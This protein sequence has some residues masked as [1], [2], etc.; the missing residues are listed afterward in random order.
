[1]EELDHTI[2][3]LF[4]L[5]RINHINFHNCR[6]TY[7]PTQCAKFPFFPGSCYIFILLMIVIFTGLRWYFF[8]ILILISLVICDFVYCLLGIYVF[9]GNVYLVVWPIFNLVIFIFLNWILKFFIYSV[10]WSFVRVFLSVGCIFLWL[11]WNNPV[12]L[13]FV[14]CVWSSCPKKIPCPL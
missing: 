2:V 5:F 11:V 3:L 10:F 13:F 12:C 8:M 6:T 4:L 14:S 7:I 1:V 9:W